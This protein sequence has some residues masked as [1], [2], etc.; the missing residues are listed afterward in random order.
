VAAHSVVAALLLVTVMTRFD[1]HS[2]GSLAVLWQQWDEGRTE[3]PV[4]AA[5]W[6]K[7]QGISGR[8]FH[9]CEDG[10]W[11]QQQG[12]GP[13]Y[14]DTGFGKYDETFIR[15]T[16]LVADRP[17]L[18]STF[19]GV[20][21]PGFVVCDDFAFQWPAY[22]Q[23]AGCRL[24]F[25]SPNSSVW[26][27]PGGQASFP[28]VGGDEVEAAFSREI[29]RD[30]LPCDLVLEGR[31]LIAL[32][33][34]GRAAFAIAQLRALPAALH[35]AGWYWEAARMICFD[36]P[37][38]P[39]GLRRELRAEADTLG[40]LTVDFRAY[41][42]EAEGRPDDARALLDKIPENQLSDREAILLLRIEMAQHLPGALALARHHHL[43]DLSDGEYWHD[44]AELEETEGSLSSAARAWHEAVFYAPDMNTV[45]AL[46]FTQRHPNAQLA[47]FILS[48]GISAG[49]MPVPPA[50]Q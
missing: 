14:A 18:L 32:N 15:E 10:G 21:R 27:A 39:A 2:D 11:L 46:A 16:G 22:L 5:A 48:S 49:Q 20:Y 7:Q 25:Y 8:L 34:L 26:V 29:K 43:F 50:L 40:D 41:D 44:R 37:Q 28:T 19:L 24:V 42:D 45:P 23:Q 6:M 17:A 31:N 35:H 38:A 9:R 13:T 36:F 1:G 33:S 3:L 12:L 4:D 30:G 47:A